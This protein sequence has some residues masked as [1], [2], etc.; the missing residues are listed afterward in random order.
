MKFL[1]KPI[2]FLNVKLFLILCI[3]GKDDADVENDET[4]ATNNT[5][6]GRYLHFRPFTGDIN[7]RPEL[8]KKNGY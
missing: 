8:M 3:L 7:E 5:A 4:K 1:F 6:T 2:S